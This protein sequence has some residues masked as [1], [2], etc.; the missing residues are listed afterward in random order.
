MDKEILL[1]ALHKA[2]DAGY[3]THQI[4]LALLIDYVIEYI[5]NT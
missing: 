1:V 5:E 4:A 2:K 3:F